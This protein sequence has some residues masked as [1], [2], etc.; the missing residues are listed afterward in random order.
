[1][2][3]SW[4]LDGWI[5][6]VGV[7][8]GVSSTLLGTFLMLRRMSLLGD[9]ISHAVLP[10]IALAFLWTGSRSSLPMFLGAVIVGV[11][12]AFFTEWVRR[13]GRVD[14]GASMGVVFTTLFALG[15]LLLVGAADQIDL[16]VDCVL[17]GNIEMTPLD[18]IAVGSLWVPR[19]ALTL[20]GVTLINLLFVMIFFKE[21]KLFCFDPAL[22][23][24]TGF[25]ASLLHY[26]MMIMVAVTAV[27]SFEAVGSVLVVAM[28]IVPAATASLLTTRLSHLLVV[29]C[30]IAALTAVIGHLGVIAIPPQL[31]LKSA[32]TAGGM[33]IAAGLL[34][35][36]AVFFAPHEG[37]IPRFVRQRR[38]SQQIMLDDV[39]AFL[40]RLRE[41]GDASAVSISRVSD[42]LMIPELRIRRSI[43]QLLADGLVEEI[44]EAI[45]LTGMGSKR[46]TD[47]V[48]SHRLWETY[49][50]DH[51]GI[52]PERLHDK[53][54][55]L[56]H[57]TDPG[58][59][60]RLDQQTAASIDPHG[61]P[62]PDEAGGERD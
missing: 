20:G 55:K 9:A 52:A 57:F 62:I 16:D 22:A 7:L 26:V 33:A 34:F 48:R 17:M 3:W 47:L 61:R 19:S 28:L 10:G 45:R 18:R 58:L 14:E 25:S 49:L 56:E 44:G 43:A 59:R 5:I 38:L 31:G 1:M 24:A 32:K 23:S 54:E 51:A 13:V 8:C 39:L 53:A 4:P 60:K 6:V 46:A 50:S 11:L 41:A 29:G 35:S 30:I 15:L 27:A 2:F 21:L 42:Q 37:L 36:L 12:T 40:F